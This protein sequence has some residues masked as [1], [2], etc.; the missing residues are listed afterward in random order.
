MLA[1][2]IP[3]YKIDY[4]KETLKSLANQTNKNF[5]VYVGNDASKNDPTTLIENT[6]IDVS[7][8]YHYFD[9]NLGGSNL[10]AQWDRCIQLMDHNE[11]WFMILGDDDYLDIN[12]VQSFYDNLKEIS[13]YNSKVIRFAVQ[14]VLEKKLESKIYKNPPLQSQND[15]FFTRERSSLSEF[16]FSLESYNKYKFKQ[17]PLAWGADVLAVY[18][19]AENFPVYSI[20]STTVFVRISDKSISGNTNKKSSIIKTTSLAEVYFYI[21]K[22][23]KN[24]ISKQQKDILYRKIKKLYFTNRGN[25]VK[26]IYLIKAYFIVKI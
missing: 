21:L 8:K 15:F 10:V 1:I 13:K 14:K 23:Y 12:F 6:L 24:T 16:I 4:F 20:N 9:K 18:E 7:Y 25:I 5:R 11:Q 3:Y 2:V 22:N 19:F 17:I 26:L